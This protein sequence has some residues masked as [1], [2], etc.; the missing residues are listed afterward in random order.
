VNTGKSNR[1]HTHLISTYFIAGKFASLRERDIVCE[2]LLYHMCS[3]VL[4]FFVGGRICVCQWN[5]NKW[6]TRL[7]M[8]IVFNVLMIYTKT[9]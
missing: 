7:G 9:I 5:K 3:V 6:Y 1:C 8:F 2:Q 4:I